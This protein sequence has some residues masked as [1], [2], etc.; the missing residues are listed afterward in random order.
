MRLL[1]EHDLF[2]GMR[3][4]RQHAVEML[5]GDDSRPGNAWGQQISSVN[6]AGRCSFVARTANS[7]SPSTQ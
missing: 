2:A 6:A 4:Y 1:A 7:A 3:L 5:R